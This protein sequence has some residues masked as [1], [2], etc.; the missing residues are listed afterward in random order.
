MYYQKADDE[1]RSH[2]NFWLSQVLNAQ[3]PS[4]QDLVW[5]KIWDLWK[6]RINIA[7]TSNDKSRFTKEIS[8]FSRL[9]KNIPFDL[10]QVHSIL[11]E[12]LKFKPNGFAI[13]EIIKYLGEN[14]ERYPDLAI[15]LLHKIVLA[16]QTVYI[17]P[18][19]KVSVERILTFAINAGNDLEA[20]AIEIINIFGERGDYSWR[21]LLDGRKE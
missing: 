20:I 5:Q 7:T 17:L 21:L 11:E 16:N 18:D 9:L 6:W 14:C 1:T 12:A 10:S 8:D 3:K 2:G 19:A 13:E 15:L 4:E